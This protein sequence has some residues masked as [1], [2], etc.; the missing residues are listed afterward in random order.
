MPTNI[1]GPN[2]NYDLE[3]GSH[4]LAAF[5]K[6]FHD[7]KRDKERKSRNFGERENPKREFIH[8]DDVSEAAYFVIKSDIGNLYEMDCPFLM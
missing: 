6:R 8:V 5:I 2:D 1:Y 7:A 4:V 3:S